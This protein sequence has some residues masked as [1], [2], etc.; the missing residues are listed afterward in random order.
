MAPASASQ[1]TADQRHAV[2]SRDGTRIGYFREGSGP[3]VILVQAAMGRAED[4]ADLARALST[5]F[6]I[7][8]PDRRGRGISLKPYDDGHDIARDVEDIDALLEA[9]GSEMV[10]G[11]SSGAVIAL[12]A[13]RTLSRIRCVAVYEPPFYA[14]GISRDGIRRLN[15]ELERGDL[16]AA[17]VTSLETSETAPTPIRILPRPIQTILARIALF[18]NPDDIRELVPGIRYDF[19]VVSGMDGKIE[20]FKE[21][22]KPVLLLSG[23]DSPAFL[24]EAVR[25]L[26]SIVPQADHVEFE[27]LG[28]SGP[29]N[30][31]KG[32]RPEA[33]A[34]DLRQFF[35][36]NEA[37]QSQ[38]SP[39]GVT[40]TGSDGEVRHV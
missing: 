40:A 31:R 26:Q 16:A 34:G 23:T 13:A 5:S 22:N 27:G 20:S 24:R 1:S 2:T 38:A 21:V 6:T 29:W 39:S 36:A 15:A 28:H 25:N 18:V 7:Y 4:Y 3:G 33:V 9:T 14:D 8:R 30:R 32:G 17:L 35:L 10:F 37:R 11:L 19:N 12:E